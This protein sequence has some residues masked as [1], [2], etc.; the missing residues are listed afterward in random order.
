MKPFEQNPVP[1]GQAER[2]AA[3]IQDLQTDFPEQGEG[4]ASQAGGLPPPQTPAFAHTLLRAVEGRARRAERGVLRSMAAQS[5]VAEEAL[6]QLLT[7]AR[8]ERDAQ[9][10]PDAG[11]E[12][13]APPEG[14]ET[15][16]AGVRP[17]ADPAPVAGEQPAAPDP[18]DAR[19]DL[20]A[21]QLIAA[22]VRRVGAEMGLWDAE[23]AL[24]LIPPK[25]LTI[26]AAGEVEGVGDALKA[27]RACKGYL[28]GRAG[29]GAW[30][31]KLDGGGLA[32]VSGVEE[33]FYR[34]NP[35]L[36]R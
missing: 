18:R 17:D 24:T 32:P 29:G 22:E 4:D 3:D 21:R 34:K 27:L 1:D 13:G 20:L 15:P 2:D 12:T 7:D 6:A 35:A 10:E 16:D 9:A 33:A 36:R 30:A 31:Q 5:G 19:A 14:L 28:F 11:S 8:A 23:V 25:A 26:N